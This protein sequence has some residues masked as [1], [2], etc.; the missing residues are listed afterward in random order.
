M[1]QFG[2]TLAK[3]TKAGQVVLTKTNATNL[4]SVT[5]DRARFHYL[6]QLSSAQLHSDLVTGAF[7]I[8]FPTEDNI[9]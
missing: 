1:C 9:P 5:P 2:P 4:G 7:S 3:Q 8:S 6:L